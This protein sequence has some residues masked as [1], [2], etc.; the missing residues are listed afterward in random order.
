M[1]VDFV[2]KEGGDPFCDDYFLGGTENYP[3]SKAMVNHNQERVKA[4]GYRQVSDEVARDLLEGSRGKK[5]D[6]GERWNGGMGI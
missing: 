5:L 3:L 1:K 6:R 2:E 4:R